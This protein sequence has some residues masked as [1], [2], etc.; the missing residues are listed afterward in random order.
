MV[1]SVTEGDGHRL[2]SIAN[3]ELKHEGLR[4]HGVPAQ[5]YICVEG[6]VIKK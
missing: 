3:I 6:K 5:Q 2:G 1:E 4:I